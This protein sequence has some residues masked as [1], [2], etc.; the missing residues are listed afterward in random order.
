MPTQAPAC[1]RRP[2]SSFRLPPSWAKTQPTSAEYIVTA[3]K[4]AMA[5]RGK[6]ATGTVLCTWRPDCVA[7]SLAIATSPA[8]SRLSRRWVLRRQ[9]YLST[10][11]HLHQCQLQLRRAIQSRQGPHLRHNT[12]LRRSNTP[13]RR[14]TPPRRNTH[15]SRAQCPTSSSRCRAEEHSNPIQCH[16]CSSQHRVRPGRLGPME[17]V[18][19]RPTTTREADTQATEVEVLASE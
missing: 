1:A 14:N 3:M 8:T 10:K 5:T 19:A 13:L 11:L 2:G 9:V 15:R 6:K 17:P 12:P 7:A 18:V 16:R 4:R